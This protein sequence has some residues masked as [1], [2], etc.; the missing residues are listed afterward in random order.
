[1]L[2]IQCAAQGTVPFDVSQFIDSEAIVASSDEE[3]W[4][5]ESEDGECL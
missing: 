5:E 2:L 3:S 4:D 1:V